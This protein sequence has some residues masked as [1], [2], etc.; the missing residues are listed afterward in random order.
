MSNPSDGHT[1]LIFSFRRGT[2]AIIRGILCW[3]KIYSRIVALKP[4]VLL[5]FVQVVDP[6]EFN[7]SILIAHKLGKTMGG[8]G[9]LQG[10]TV[11]GKGIFLFEIPAGSCLSLEGYAIVR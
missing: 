3:A 4:F 7:H 8:D 11:G 2:G 6:I 10:I 1:A 5:Q 9:I